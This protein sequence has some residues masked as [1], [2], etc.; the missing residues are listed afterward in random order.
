MQENRNANDDDHDG[1]Y[2]VNKRA[3]V[4]LSKTKRPSS[5]LD[6]QDRDPHTNKRIEYLTWIRFQSCKVNG[7]VNDIKLRLNYFFRSFNSIL[8]KVYVLD[9]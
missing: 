9:I 1:I 2:E 8:G 5:S 6:Q 4:T 3:L 7:K